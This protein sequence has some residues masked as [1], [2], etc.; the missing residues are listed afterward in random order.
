MNNFK[1]GDIV[2]SSYEQ[3]YEN[4]NQ[5][6][7]EQFLIMDRFEYNNTVDYL[8]ESNK[9][10]GIVGAKSLH[11]TAEEA[12][13]ASVENI[14]KTEEE[15]R[16]AIKT[17]DDVI[18]LY[19]NPNKYIDELKEKISIK[20]VKK[21]DTKR[22][23]R[24]NIRIRSIQKPV[25]TK[26]KYSP[27]DEVFLINDPKYYN[28]FSE[29]DNL[30]NGLYIKKLKNN[31]HLIKECTDDGYFYDKIYEPQYIAKSNAEL[32][33]IQNIRYYN[34][35]LKYVNKIKTHNSLLDFLKIN[36][37]KSGITRY[38]QK[39]IIEEALKKLTM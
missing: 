2:Y 38:E 13:R 11:E 32:D 19:I 23:K 26:E 10:Q 37:S 5:L 30:S 36:I 16:N 31:L 7:Q 6:V 20:I 4:L 9:S 34:R 35:V 8:I 14:N 24:G 29:T 17:M 18:N 33:K 3:P 1:I 25:K 39:L 28:R 12:Y 15:L 27:C 22:I 21:E